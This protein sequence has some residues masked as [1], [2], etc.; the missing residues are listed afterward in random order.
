[1]PEFSTAKTTPQP[2][3][4]VGSQNADKYLKQTQLLKLEQKNFSF[5][6]QFPQQKSPLSAIAK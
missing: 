5:E 1:M 2:L 6:I 3:L 4:K